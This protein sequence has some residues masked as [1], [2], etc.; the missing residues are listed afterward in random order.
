M[1]II[2]LGCD[3]TAIYKITKVAQFLVDNK[4]IPN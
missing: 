2:A 1:G 3:G 4:V